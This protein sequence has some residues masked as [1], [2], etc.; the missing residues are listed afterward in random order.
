MFLKIIL[1]FG[2]ALVFIFGLHCCTG[3]SLVAAS[4]SYFPGALCGLL[5]VVASHVEVACG[6]DSCCSGALELKAQ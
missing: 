3:F 5:I 4:G 6:L 1:I 2:C